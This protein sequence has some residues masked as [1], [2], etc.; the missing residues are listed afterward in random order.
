MVSTSVKEIEKEKRFEFGKNWASFLKNL[1]DIK[2]EH[3]TNDL[4]DKLSKEDLSGL[5]FLDIGCGSGLHSLSAAK[6][7]V[8]KLYSFDF[9]EHS[10]NCCHELK[11]RYSPNSDN[12][13]IE[14]GSALD[15][16][17]IESLGLFDIVYS[18]GVLHHTGN[19][20]LA[21]NNASKAVKPGGILFIS[22]YNDQGAFSNLWR[23]IKKI[24]IHS[25]GFIKW[26]IEFSVS[27]LYEI[28]RAAFRIVRL[29]NP[30]PFKDWQEYY[31]HRGMSYWTN[32]VDWV[33][34][35]PFEVAK[36]EEIFHYF[37]QR[38]FNLEDLETT[39]GHGCNIFVF[40]KNLE[41][42]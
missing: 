4:K 21:L 39:I 35:Y 12:W 40:R 25:P 29:Q 24:Y 5:S 1:D 3:A 13:I 2:I 16:E 15:T 10:V 8:S 38:N 9:D 27:F 26:L 31:K 34:G 18:W 41:T 28:G 22:I 36:P 11:N 37:K 33:G 30:L 17:Y 20:E 23:F 7:G 6:L 42:S 14:Q 19:M 32:V